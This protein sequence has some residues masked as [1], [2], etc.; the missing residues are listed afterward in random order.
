M[1]VAKI[2]ELSSQSPESFEHAIKEGLE[3]ASKTI[4]NITGAWVKEMKVDLTNNRITNY[5]VIM[6]VT[7]VLK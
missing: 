1:S 7:F 5:R 2:V 6:R 3:R 4:E